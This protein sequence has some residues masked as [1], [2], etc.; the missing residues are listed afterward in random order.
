MRNCCVFSFKSPDSDVGTGRFL[1]PKTMNGTRFGLN[2]TSGYHVLNIL[3]MQLYTR[4]LAG[5]D[6][7]NHERFFPG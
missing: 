4:G 2:F 1:N 7:G 5:V 3:I 6:P